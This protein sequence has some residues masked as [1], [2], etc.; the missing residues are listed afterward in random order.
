MHAHHIFMT[1]SY[2]YTYSM[3]KYTYHFDTHEHYNWHLFIY[4]RWDYICIE[5]LYIIL[6]IMSNEV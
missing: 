2:M 5:K 1:H 4:T 6:S 3:H